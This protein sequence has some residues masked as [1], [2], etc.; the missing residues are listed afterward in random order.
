MGYMKLIVHKH[1]QFIFQKLFMK[2]P[3]TYFV[4]QAMTDDHCPFLGTKSPILALISGNR[5]FDLSLGKQVPKGAFYKLNAGQKGFYRVKYDE[6]NR[7]ALVKLF[8]EHHED[9]H[10]VDRAGLLDDALN[11]AR[12]GQLPYEKA[13]ALTG[14]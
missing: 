13:L 6:A 4:K 12:A 8:D 7:E 10:P 11:L 2:S 1:F 3:I 14:Q 9:L 5:T